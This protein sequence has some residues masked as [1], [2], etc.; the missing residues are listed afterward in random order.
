MVHYYCLKNNN[1]YL[2]NMYINVYNIYWCQ[3][4]I[5]I[6]FQRCGPLSVHVWYIYHYLPT[7]TIKIN[8]TSSSPP[9]KKKSTYQA[10]KISSFTP[11]F[12]K[13]PPLSGQRKLPFSPGPS[14]PAI[15]KWIQPGSQE[16]GNPQDF[17][18]LKLF[19]LRVGGK[20]EICVFLPQNNMV[21]FKG[22][23]ILH[24]S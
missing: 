9:T 12:Q 5:N 8:Q 15:V 20:S 22:W 3:F 4:N 13:F 7:C 17:T 2:R 6:H 21:K 11:K 1:T 19:L 23:M 24:E 18:S 16:W 10:P 14:H